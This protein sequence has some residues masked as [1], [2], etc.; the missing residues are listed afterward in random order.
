[1]P[2]MRTKFRPINR[3]RP[4]PGAG[5]RGGG[6]TRW[7]RIGKLSAYTA[8]A[9]AGDVGVRNGSR[10]DRWRSADIQGGTRLRQLVKA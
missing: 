4:G 5:R 2:W 6:A 7:R 3:A 10:R 1:V 8:P 9:A